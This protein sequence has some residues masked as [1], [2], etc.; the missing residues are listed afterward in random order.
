MNQ[1]D[2]YP[3]D[4]MPSYYPP[5]PKTS[6]RADLIDKIKPEP[7][8]ELIRNRLMGKELIDGVWMDVPALKDRK[9]TDIGAW[10]I[11]NLLQGVSHIGVTISKFKDA[12]IKKRVR[13]ICRTAQIMLVQ[14]FDMYGIKNTA[15]MWFVHEILFTTCYALLKQADDASI[16]D[17]LGKVVQENRTIA[18]EGKVGKMQKLK[19]SM[20]LT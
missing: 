14:N 6:D 1:E 18:V 13:N 20:G 8:V 5:I 16:Q 9:L 4:S 19:D 11:S 10:E 15:Q 2:Y 17:L 12:E 3:E 7:V